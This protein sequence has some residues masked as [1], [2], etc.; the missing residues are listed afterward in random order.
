MAPILKEAEAAVV[1]TTTVATAPAAPH[2]KSPADA[3]ARPQPIPLEIPVSVNG[4]R[5]VEGS[6]KREPFSETTLTVL[7]FPL[8]AVIR[9]A[10]P[11]VPGQ[12]IFLTNEKT[13]K[14]VVC[15]VVKSKPAGTAAGYVE[16]RFTEPAAGFWGVSFPGA[17]A[18][19]VA[20]HPAAPVA[21]AA[22]KTIPPVS[23]LAATSPAHKPVTTPATFIP[24]AK[25]GIAPLPLPAAKQQPTGPQSVAPASPPHLISIAPSPA[26]ATVLEPP[27]AQTAA[28]IAPAIPKLNTTPASSTPSTEELK[29]EAARLQAQLS[30]LLF[31]ETPAAQPAPSVPPVTLKAEPPAAEV[32]KKVLEIVQEEPKPAAKS[33]PRPALPIHKPIP[34]SLSANEEVK[35]PAWLA[36]LSQNSE[37][38]VA[39]NADSAN[40]SSESASH[41]LAHSEDSS[42]ILVADEPRH[43]HST[44]FGGQLLGESSVQPEQVT[45]KGSRKGLF[46]GFAAATVLLIGGGWY[47]RQSFSASV[48]VAAVKPVS[49]PTATPPAAAKPDLLSAGAGSTLATST[50]NPAPVASSTI[51][52]QPLKNS[53]PAAT[54]PALPAAPEP[55]NSNPAPR[56]PAPIEPPKKAGLGNVHLAAPVVNRGAGSQQASDTLPTIE[57]NNA[58]AGSDALAAVAS[59]HRKEPV[60]PLPV[61]GDVKPAK[62]IK[63]TPPVYP[64]VAKAQHISGDVLIDALIDASG[65]VATVQ[66]IS[67]PAILH[68]AALD[69]LKQWRYSPA[70]LDGQPTSMHL[71]VTVQFRV[72]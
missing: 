34:V 48:P 52:S 6:D 25:P 9:M 47:F 14:E 28:P 23:P 7:V 31:R 3:P 12:L 11:L 56:N 22:P 20:H 50:V 70:L 16:L 63:S 35:I 19:P 44:V 37:Q 51:S 10:T 8:G 43:Q 42:D 38:S 55:K 66:I 21:P 13:K 29:L 65:N 60:A 61:G 57:T 49:T 33:E 4:A 15:Q 41:V 18:A 36:P 58:S 64:Q 69:A 53:A 2:P 62:L 40:V 67:G 68:R 24:P 72:Q 54:Q 32:A 59:A 17:S 46:L 39:E 1:A 71:T 26:M 45:S 27:P 30:T 5:T